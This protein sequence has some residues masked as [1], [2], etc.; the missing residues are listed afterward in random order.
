MKKKQ[1]KEKKCVK[2]GCTQHNSCVDRHGNPCYWIHDN[3]CS[4]CRTFPFTRI[5]GNKQYHVNIMERDLSLAEEGL[6]Y[7]DLV[8]IWRNNTKHNRDKFI[9]A[10]MA[11]MNK[12]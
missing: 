10:L 11:E 1:P 8:N 3:L 6:L 9:K 7:T 4:A 5:K 12:N 2:C